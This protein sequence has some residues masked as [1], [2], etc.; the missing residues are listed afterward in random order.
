MATATSRSAWLCGIVLSLVV[1]L[2]PTAPALAEELTIEDALVRLAAESAFVVAA[3]ADAN[4]DIQ[5]GDA[6]PLPEGA[7]ATDPEQLCWALRQAG[8]SAFRWHDGWVVS[9]RKTYELD[10]QDDAVGEMQKIEAALAILGPTD[11]PQRRAMLMGALVRVGDLPPAGALAI[12]SYVGRRINDARDYT[13]AK[14]RARIAV[15]FLLSTFTYALDADGH[16]VGLLDDGHRGVSLAPSGGELRL[17]TDVAGASFWAEPYWMR[18][19]AGTRAVQVIRDGCGTPMPPVEEVVPDLPVLAGVDPAELLA[20]VAGQGQPPV[21]PGQVMWSGEFLNE[22][23]PAGGPRCTLASGLR[24]RQ[25]WVA[26]FGPASR[27]EL[28]EAACLA[29]PAEPVA[30]GDGIRIEP[31]TESKWL[32]QVL[33]PMRDEMRRRLAEVALVPMLALARATADPAT[34]PAPLAPWPT[35]GGPPTMILSP[36]E[37][38][39]RRL[40]DDVAAH[41]TPEK[42]R[43]GLEDGSLVAA[44]CARISLVSC[45]VMRR[46]APAGASPE[47]AGYMGDGLI[48]RALVTYSH[49][50]YDEPRFR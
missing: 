24:K 38:R 50:G 47:A 35:D 9:L 17:N 21:W 10:E 29:L 4:G 7:D 13:G 34:P 33:Q 11:S 5:L 14:L 49:S 6:L 2:L 32:D 20:D 22:L 45:R 39:G 43:E 40:S 12:E 16:A 48:Q 37:C 44:V 31:D 26:T 1:A 8:A 25:F 28:L 46:E 42:V 36:E 3:M 27:L 41:W 15:A 23:L 30:D 18:G 19:D